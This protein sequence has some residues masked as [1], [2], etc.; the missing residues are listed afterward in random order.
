MDV[1]FFCFD[2]RSVRFAFAGEYR[3][4]FYLAVFAAEHRIYCVF[5]YFCVL[6]PYSVLTKMYSS[7]VGEHVFVSAT[8]SSGL[9]GHLA[10]HGQAYLHKS[11]G[12]VL[13]V[14]WRGSC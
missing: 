6:F 7:Y 4:R 13:G 8:D 10:G 2:E 9:L 1:P 11:G 3:L 12:H 14:S 5:R